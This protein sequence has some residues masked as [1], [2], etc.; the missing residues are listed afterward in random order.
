MKPV[1][2]HKGCEYQI[3]GN[4]T[5][6]HVGHG[7]KAIIFIHDIFGLDSGRSR[8]VADEFADHG[9]QVFFPDLF[10]GDTFPDNGKFDTFS[11]WLKKH[12]T[13][14]LTDDVIN[15]VLPYAKSK[16][17]TSIGMIGFCWGSY[18]MTHLCLLYPEFKAVVHPHPSYQL[19]S[20]LGED[21]AAALNKVTCP[22][23]YMPAGNDEVGLKPNGALIALMEKNLGE[24]VKSVEFPKMQHGWFVR[25]D[26]A[27]PKI[28]EDYKESFRLSVEFF[29]K[30]L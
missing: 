15:H 4:L 1:P 2:G 13:N 14:G 6:Y 22:Q 29:Q 18:L 24:K 30:Y 11:Q 12:P 7:E 17:A 26:L 27:D 9:Y 23:L 25:G 28:A 3:E 20:M 19:F 10:R 16:G 8:K 21:G 5:L